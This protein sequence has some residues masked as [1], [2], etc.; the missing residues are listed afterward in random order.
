[1]SPSLTRSGGLLEPTC[2]ANTVYPRPPPLLVEGQS[3]EPTRAATL[4]HVDPSATHRKELQPPLA[5]CECL[6]RCGPQSACTT[7]FRVVLGVAHVLLDGQ[8]QEQLV[9]LCSRPQLRTPP[10]RWDFRTSWRS[11]LCPGFLWGRG[12]MGS[13][14]VKDGGN[15]AHPRSVIVQHGDYGKTF[16][17]V[18]GK[19]GV[20]V[21]VPGGLA[22]LH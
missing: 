9:V 16:S 18:D 2:T 4:P 8:M 1:M 7:A 20:G 13:A 6:S 17:P 11:K 14:P 10:S 19:T 3:D 21:C 15:E 5:V 12:I 22:H